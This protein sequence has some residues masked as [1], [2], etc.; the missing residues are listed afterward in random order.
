VSVAPE[1]T[2]TAPNAPGAIVLVTPELSVTA[3]VPAVTVGRGGGAG[4][5]GNA[6][7]GPYVAPLLPSTWSV[8]TGPSETPL[9]R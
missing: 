7:T 6:A 3:V 4:I 1:F 9:F 2:V 8:S 5:A